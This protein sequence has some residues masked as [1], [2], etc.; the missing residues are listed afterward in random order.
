M[1][2]M[3]KVKPN[4]AGENNRVEQRPLATGPGRLVTKEKTLAS[5]A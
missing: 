1:I 4:K 2:K 3:V 5:H